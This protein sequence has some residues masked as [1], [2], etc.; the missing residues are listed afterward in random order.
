M[1]SYLQAYGFPFLCIKGPRVLVRY[2]LSTYI[3]GKLSR[4]VGRSLSLVPPYTWANWKGVRTVVNSWLLSLV[5]T[6]FP[7]GKPVSLRQCF[8][9]PHMSISLHPVPHPSQKKRLSYKVP[10]CPG[11]S[12][13]SF[14]SPHSP[15][16]L[17][18]YSCT[19]SSNGTTLCCLW[20]LDSRHITQMASLSTSQ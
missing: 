4:G 7:L 3:R 9:S 8:F 6:Q 12:S 1:S 16:L 14:K 13:T 2:R 11:F 10:S 17:T 15:T 18:L 19:A 5:F 20:L